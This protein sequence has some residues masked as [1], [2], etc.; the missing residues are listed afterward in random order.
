MPEMVFEYI[1]K[2]N[3]INPATDLSIVQNINFG[4]TAGAFSGGQG[5]YTVEFE[6]LLLRWN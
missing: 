5:E 4:L 2:Q 3:G 6:P 1:L